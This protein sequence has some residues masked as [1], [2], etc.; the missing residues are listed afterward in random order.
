MP[1]PDPSDQ[2]LVTYAQNREDLFPWAL[3]GHRTPG[4]YVDV[5]CYDERLHSVTRLFYDQGWS[6]L[7]IDANDQFASQYQER[8][9]DRFVWTGIGAEEGEMSFRFYPNPRTVSRRS[10]TT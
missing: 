1:L 3:V 8:E 6:G 10:T 9:R 7:N 5:G 2:P 4:T